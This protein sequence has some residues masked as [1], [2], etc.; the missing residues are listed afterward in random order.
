MN[1]RGRPVVSTIPRVGLS[2]CPMAT[3]PGVGVRCAAV[4]AAAVLS[5]AL[6]FPRCDAQARPLDSLL[7]SH[8]FPIRLGPDGLSG[9]GLDVVLAAAAQSQ[10]ILIAEEHNVGQLSDFAAGL[11]EV[12]EARL[13]FRYAALE[14]GGV[15]TRWLSR[16]AR[17][18][19][20]D[21]VYS[22]AR[23]WPHAPTFATDQ[24]LEMIARMVDASPAGHDPVWGV[25]QEFGALHLLERLAE[26]APN[27]AARQRAEALAQ[28][29][30]QYEANRS[31][32]TLYLAQVATPSDFESLP[33]LFAPAPGSEA[34]S[35]ID[36]LQRTNRIYY[37]HTLAQ[38]GEPTAYENAREREGSMKARFMA[39]YRR[40]QAAGDTLPKV[41]LK[42]GHWHIY[43]GIYR[44]DVPTL[45]NFVSE[46]AT[47]NGSESFLIAT[48]VIE[49]P[50]Q[51]RNS[52]S[53]VPLALPGEQFTLID[54]RPLR[55][56][57]HQNMI[58]DLAE[59]WRSLLFR[60]DAALI[61]RG[62]GTGSYAVTRGER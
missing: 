60:A 54:F 27:P 10:F 17:A 42:L 16:A 45:G 48:W 11:F 62:G 13:G 1:R 2:D 52:A 44:G 50:D 40:A 25:D 53:F 20:L 22:L 55:P 41:L 6:V 35:L 47:A 8:A 61:I 43:R 49:G 12:L 57:A 59:P 34:E 38:R 5:L 14:Q 3:P 31:G 24:E 56:Y 33:R 9:A 4:T 18:G 37:N 29:A 21:S 32:D 19:G 51:W 39:E 46:L 26:L 58:A 36:A 7:L 30:R 23:R 28:A 15:I